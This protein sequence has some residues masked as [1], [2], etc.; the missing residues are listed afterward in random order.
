MQRSCLI[1]FLM[2]SVFSVSKAQTPIVTEKFDQLYIGENFDSSS[3]YWTTL[4]NA[5]NL[6]IVQEGEYIMHRKASFSPYAVMANFNVDL[7]AYRLVTS[8]KLDKTSAPD[9]S[10]GI[11]FMAQSDGKGG[12][13]FEINKDQKYR[14][15]QITGH[16]YQY[17]SGTAKDAGWVQSEVLKGL[18]L[19]NLVEVRTANKKYDLFVNNSLLISFESPEYKTG[20]I[21]FIIGPSSKGKA[22]FLY[23]FTNEKAKSLTDSTNVDNKPSSP[24][25]DVIALA[26]SIISL[27]TEINKL[28]EQ[29]EDLRGTVSSMKAGQKEM[30]LTKNSY[31]ARIK[32]LES[33]VKNVTHSFDSLMKV[34]NDL[35]K[36][37]EMVQGNDN[38]D[39]VINLSKN[40]KNEKII[41]DE[42]RKT[43]KQLTDSIM[44][45]KN[46]LKESKNKTTVTPVVKQ[47][48]AT[49]KDSLIKP[50]ETFT[51]PKEN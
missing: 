8:I 1:L 15:R 18:N 36:Y 19:P 28:Q 4:S 50:K 7:D 5:D 23:L 44:Q 48:E 40:L 9:G 2:L 6:L 39:L 11:I 32:V 31:D 12:F 46:Q 35:M 43:N 29:N 16:A 24:E 13:I 25:T 47:Q 51:L 27:K 38:G 3:S 45:L 37:K 20:G 26:E 41:N 10:I 17:I 42:L 33:Q 34:K 30:E 21:G 22:D 14:L 49:K